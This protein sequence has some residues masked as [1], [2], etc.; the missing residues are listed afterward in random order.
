MSKTLNEMREELAR[1]L[2]DNM[3]DGTLYD[4]LMNGC[5]GY[6]NIEAELVT[7]EYENIFGEIE[8]DEDEDDVQL[9]KDYKNGLYGE[10]YDP[11]T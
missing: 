11:C 9:E 2:V 7:E 1:H 3:D 6:N 8:D 5:E 4:I 10:E